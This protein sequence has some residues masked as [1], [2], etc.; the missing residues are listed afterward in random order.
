MNLNNIDASEACYVYCSIITQLITDGQANLN[1]LSPALRDWLE[2]IRKN[3][4]YEEPRE[5]TAEYN[6]K[7]YANHY[8]PND[9]EDLN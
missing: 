7:Y 9:E 3:T 1:N 2:T 6:L 8:F 4:G 5:G